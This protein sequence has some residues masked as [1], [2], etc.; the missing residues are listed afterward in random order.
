MGKAEKDYIDQLDAQYKRQSVWTKD[1]RNRIYRQIGI[2]GARRVL[3]VGCGTGTITKEIREK[4]SAQITAID[5]DHLVIA[6]AQENITDVEFYRMSV[7]K[8]SFRD[9]T[10]NIVLCN[11]FFMWLDKPF[12]SLMEMV[13]VCKTGGYIVAL[14]EPDYGGWIEHPDFGLGKQHIE[15]IKKQGA[16]PFVGRKILSL[17][18]SAGLETNISVVANVWEKERLLE[19]IKNEWKLVLET[20]QITDEE[21][22]EIMKKEVK[23]IE[24]NMRMIFLPIFSAVGKKVRCVQEPKT[25]SS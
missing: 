19:Q 16:D 24:E 25:T 10:F 13:R 23:T 21:Y 22:Q 12:K 3:E 7:E 6:T 17:F 18:E 5:R 1:Y 14:A 8:M 11:Y 4:T 15:G 2:K 9:E 20:E